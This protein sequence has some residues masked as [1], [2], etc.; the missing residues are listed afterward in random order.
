MAEVITP[1]GFCYSFNIID[2]DEL[3]KTEK[4]V[5]KT[6]INLLKLLIFQSRLDFQLFATNFLQECDK[7][8]W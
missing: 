5:D 2:A 1:T 7:K 4:F 8:E 3:L 6:S